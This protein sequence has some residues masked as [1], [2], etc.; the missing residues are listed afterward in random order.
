MEYKK[1]DREGSGYLW[2]ENTA[3]VIEKGTFT[4]NGR[5]RYGGIIKSKNSNGEDKLEFFECI[6]VGIK[7]LRMAHH[8]QVLVLESLM[9]TIHQLKKKI[10]LSSA[11]FY[12]QGRYLY[13]TRKN[14]NR[15]ALDYCSNV[16]S[17][18]D[19]N[20]IRK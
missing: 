17:S 12:T 14:R 7:R 4:L 16:V 6:A 9:K 15:I 19:R 5:V 11:K 18:N 8:I 1:E 3:E 2:R 20:K 10:Y 13:K